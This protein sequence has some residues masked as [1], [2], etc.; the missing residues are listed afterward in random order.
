MNAS[1]QKLNIGLFF[2]ISQLSNSNEK[3]IDGL[4]LFEFL[5]KF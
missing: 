3:K 1:K 2:E 5:E 4:K